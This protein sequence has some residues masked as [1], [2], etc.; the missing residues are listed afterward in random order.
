[1]G[2]FKWILTHPRWLLAILSF[3]GF[4]ALGVRYEQFRIPGPAERV[5]CWIGENFEDQ[6]GSHPANEKRPLTAYFA[7]L[8]GGEQPDDTNALVGAV[9]RAGISE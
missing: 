2:I 5:Q 6:W 4:F 3:I 8:D 7:R 1:M 9:E